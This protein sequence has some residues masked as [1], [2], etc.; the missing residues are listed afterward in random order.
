[1]DSNYKSCSKMIF[2]LIVVW[3]LGFGLDV[4]FGS[5]STSNVTCDTNPSIENID[6]R[7]TACA[8]KVRLEISIDVFR[9][10][11]FKPNVHLKFQGYGETC[12]FYCRSGFQP[13]GVV[14]CGEN[15]TWSG[16]QSC[17]GKSFKTLF[18]VEKLFSFSKKFIKLIIS[19]VRT[20]ESLTHLNHVA[21]S[22][23]HSILANS[24]S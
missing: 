10:F 4:T 24:S 23:G 13:S 15:G 2:Q 22:I 6:D 12:T 5:N 1:M 19:S 17:T 7:S 21:S 8:F 3:Y 11:F 14:T 9:L 18:L 20:F 16:G